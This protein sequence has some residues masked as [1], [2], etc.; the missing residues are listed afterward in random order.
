MRVIQ[1]LEQ[2]LTLSKVAFLNEAACLRLQQPH[3][4][5]YGVP[6]LHELE[7]QCLNLGNRRR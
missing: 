5:Q 6:L 4:L 1:A 2:H 3:P 7:H